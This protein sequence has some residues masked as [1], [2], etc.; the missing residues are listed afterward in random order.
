MKVLKL[1]AGTV[2]TVFGAIGLGV[3]FVVITPTFIIIPK[4]KELIKG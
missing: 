2:A 4:L 3:L 1:V